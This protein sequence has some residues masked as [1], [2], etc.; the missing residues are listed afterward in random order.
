[1]FRPVR[2]IDVIHDCVAS[3]AVVNDMGKKKD[4]QNIYNL[5]Y[6]DIIVYFG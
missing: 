4:K 3:N 2:S 6:R 1:M 5:S